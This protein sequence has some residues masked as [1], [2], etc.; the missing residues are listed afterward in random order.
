MRFVSAARAALP[1]W[2]LAP[3]AQG[4]LPDGSRI[5]RGGGG[6]FV[7]KTPSRTWGFR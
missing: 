3:Q 6:L 2:R 5:H 4:P 7:G 1:T